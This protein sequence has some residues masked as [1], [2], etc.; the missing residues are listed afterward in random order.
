M[1]EV[2]GQTETLLPTV[3]TEVSPLELFFHSPAGKSTRLSAQPRL[4]FLT[5]GLFCW[6]VSAALVKS[7]CGVQKGIGGW[8]GGLRAAGGASI[9][10]HLIWPSIIDTSGTVHDHRRIYRLHLHYWSHMNFSLLFFSSS[11]LRMQNSNVC[12]GRRGG[13]T[14]WKSSNPHFSYRATQAAQPS[15]ADSLC[16]HREAACVVYC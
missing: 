15:T 5:V 2:T 11:T 10:I 12:G 1:H 6:N 7:R 14:S 16:L 9:A 13:V 3:L 8:V 4:V